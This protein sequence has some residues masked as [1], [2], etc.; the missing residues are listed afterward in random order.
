LWQHA[1]EQLPAAS[2]PQQFLF[3]PA[4]PTNVNLKVDYPTLTAMAVR[5]RAQAPAGAGV[6]GHTDELTG[7]LIGLWC[8]LLGRTD[9]DADT[10]FFV[11]GGH[12]LLGA[13]LMQLA[14]QVADVQLRL[15]D[16]FAQPTPAALAALIR[17]RRTDTD[18]GA[19]DTGPTAAGADPTAAGADPT[20]AGAMPRLSDPSGEGMT[21]DAG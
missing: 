18:P 8:E 7:R 6:G 17:Q 2:V 14:E 1:R 19:G 5:H 3:L 16:L 11:H 15:A 20:A 13:K 10:N 21:P 9:V 12:S 4:L